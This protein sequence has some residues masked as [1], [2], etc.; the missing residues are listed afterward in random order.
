MSILLPIISFVLG[1]FIGREF[2]FYVIEHTKDKKS[3]QDIL[4]EVKMSL[5]DTPTACRIISPSERVQ[6]HKMDKEYG[7][8]NL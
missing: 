5:A 8:D 1:I 6:K 4:T 3:R 7:A 2:T